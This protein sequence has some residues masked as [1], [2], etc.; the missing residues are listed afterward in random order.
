MKTLMLMFIGLCYFFHQL[1]CNICLLCIF[2]RTD[3]QCT[4]SQCFMVSELV[5]FFVTHFCKIGFSWAIFQQEVP[6]E[7]VEVA[8]NLVNSFPDFSAQRHPFCH[9]SEGLWSCIPWTLRIWD[10]HVVQT[11]FEASSETSISPAASYFHRPLTLWNL[12]LLSKGSHYL[13]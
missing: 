11:G 6:M 2:I 4:F 3:F 8:K 9:C 12:S 7:W 10:S 1:C 13:C 5:S